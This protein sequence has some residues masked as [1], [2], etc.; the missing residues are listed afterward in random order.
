MAGGGGG[1]GDAAADV[2]SVVI[3]GEL[4][5]DDVD[6]ITVVV[7]ILLLLL[8]LATL[9]WTFLFG[10]IGVEI[11]GGMRVL[12]HH[13]HDVSRKKTKLWLYVGYEQMEVVQ[14]WIFG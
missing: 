8:L 9:D 14:F 4:V 13:S 11:W 1:C 6:P 7:A 3:F 5:N 12:I 10:F 2:V